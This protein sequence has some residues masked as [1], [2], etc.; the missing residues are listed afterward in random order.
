LG[1]RRLVADEIGDLHARAGLKDDDVLVEVESGR[2]RFRRGLPPPTAPTKKRSWKRLAASIRRGHPKG[3]SGAEAPPQGGL[4]PMDRRGPRR[5]LLT[6]ASPLLVAPMKRWPVSSA[7]VSEPTAG[8]L[9]V[10]QSP[11]RVIG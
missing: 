7:P 6:A 3:Q 4:T 1:P 8:P 2:A 10:T 5:A 11:R 9:C